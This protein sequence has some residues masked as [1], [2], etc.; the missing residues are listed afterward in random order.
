MSVICSYINTLPVVAEVNWSP[1][2]W[3]PWASIYQRQSVCLSARE[4]QQTA[5]ALL[6]QVAIFPALMLRVSPLLITEINGMDRVSRGSWENSLLIYDIFRSVVLNHSSDLVDA[7]VSLYIWARTSGKVSG[8][9]KRGSS[10]GILPYF[11]TKNLLTLNGYERKTVY[12]NTS[13]FVLE[14]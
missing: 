8:L 10:V 2:D 7:F 3:Q 9:G 1:P 12:H 4:Q 14:K 6:I 5:S 13:T 11:R